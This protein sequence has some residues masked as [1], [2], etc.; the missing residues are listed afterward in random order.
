MTRLELRQMMREEWRQAVAPL[1]DE[2][3]AIQAFAG[4]FSHREVARRFGV[5]HATVRDEWIK[6]KGL[7]AAKQGHNYY[8]KREDLEQWLT[9]ERR[10]AA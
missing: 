9:G 7:P 6:Q 3:A 4:V 1:L 2:L 5:T 10:E 8:I